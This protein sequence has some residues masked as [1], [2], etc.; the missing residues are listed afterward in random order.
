MGWPSREPAPQPTSCLTAITAGPLGPQGPFQNPVLP[1][2][3]FSADQGLSELEDTQANFSSIP[4]GV[5][6]APIGDSGE[7]PG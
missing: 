7:Q 3:A 4:G 2:F 6:K 1:N 5:T